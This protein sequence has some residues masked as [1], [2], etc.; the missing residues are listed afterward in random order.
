MEKLFF[1]KQAVTNPVVLLDE[2]P[3]DSQQPSF[4]GKTIIGDFYLV[5]PTTAKE[6]FAIQMLEHHKQKW[7]HKS[8]SAIVL[9]KEAAEKFE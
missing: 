7:A 9:T 8:S 2:S 1:N 3:P 6:I 4:T 5:R